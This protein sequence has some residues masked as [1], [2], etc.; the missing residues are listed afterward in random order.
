MTTPLPNLPKDSVN[1]CI[2][3]GPVPESN[4]KIE[5]NKQL[6]QVKKP[7][8]LQRTPTSGVPQNNNGKNDSLVNYL[9]F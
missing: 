1:S 4:R 8:E 7:Y 2:K 6:A 5:N 3:K 9:Y